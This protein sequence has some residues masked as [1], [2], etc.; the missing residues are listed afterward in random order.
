MKLKAILCYCPHC[1]E[2][3]RVRP[4][5]VGVPSICRKCGESFIMTA[6]P[7]QKIFQRKM[8]L[9]L[10]RLSLLLYP[11]MI[12]TW[13]VQRTTWPFLVVAAMVLFNIWCMLSV[14]YA[15]TADRMA[16]RKEA[17]VSFRF[18]WVVLI[19]L[20]FG[21]SIGFYATQWKSHCLYTLRLVSLGLP[22]SLFFDSIW[23][24]VVL[25]RT[26][27]RNRELLSGASSTIASIVP[28]ATIAVLVWLGLLPPTSWPWILPIA[29]IVLPFL[30]TAAHRILLKP[31]SSDFIFKHVAIAVVCAGL[32]WLQIML[33]NH[34]DTWLFIVI[35]FVPIPLLGVTT[36][37]TLVASLFSATI[38]FSAGIFYPLRMAYG[39]R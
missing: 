14:R 21:A 6:A 32:T 19:V 31:E 34:F 22:I 35:G 12:I 2:W 15:T 39:I 37:I 7:D 28:F 10:K 33:A 26:S 1:G 8:L 5:L 27:D 36:L 13:L 24:L 11:A 3:F 29:V 16:T 9:I 38:L 20:L 17:P 30:L 18:L 25:G 4:H 23:S